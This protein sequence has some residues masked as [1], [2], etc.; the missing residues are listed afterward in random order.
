MVSR[1]ELSEQME[2]PANTGNQRLLLS[3][4]CQGGVCYLKMTPANNIMKKTDKS[5][6]NN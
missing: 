6:P 5:S 4:V 2:M 3:G 1:V